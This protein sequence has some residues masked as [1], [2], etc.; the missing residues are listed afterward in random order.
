MVMPYVPVLGIA[1]SLPILLSSVLVDEGF[2]GVKQLFALHL[3]LC[4]C[5]LVDL[6]SCS[7]CFLVS[8]PPFVRGFVT[9]SSTVPA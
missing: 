3:F 2:D 4:D 6:I 8:D 7:S 1:I 9:N 5:L